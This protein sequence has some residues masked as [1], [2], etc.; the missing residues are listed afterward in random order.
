MSLRRTSTVVVGA[1]AYGLGM[2]H[3]L[4]DLGIDHLLLERGPSGDAWR[5]RR[6]QSLRLLTPNWANGLPGAPY[7]G[8]DPDGFMAAAAFADSLDS[9]R[10]R[11]A[12]PVQSGIYVTGVEQ[13]AGGFELATTRGP[14]H[15]R[16]LVAATGACGTAIRPPLADALPESV[17]QLTPADYSAPS[18]LPAGTVLI[19]GASASGVQ[20]AREIQSSGRQ[21]VLAVGRHI[22]LP[23]RYRDRDIYW[24]LDAV[25]AMDERFDRVEDL[26]RARRAPSPQLSG[27]PGAVDLTAL[28]AL[29]VELVGRLMEIRGRH[30]L[31]SGGLT[32]Q[33]AAADAKLTLLLSRFDDHAAR[34]MAG[35]DLPEP[36][37]LP[38]VLPP[39]TPR[40][41]IDLEAGEIGSVIWATGYRP[42]L[43]WLTLPVADRRGRLAHTGGVVD[44]VP[45][46]Y[47]LGLP[48]LRRRRS[49]L[50]SGI[51]PDCADLANHIATRLAASRA[52]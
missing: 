44:G 40:L 19:V 48:F 34:D 49:G 35:S 8:P 36:L 41:E 11:I 2:S 21:V 15:C 26:H 7:A 51:G 13:R 24:W 45:G 12:A 22:R 50:I 20:L 46:L 52:A 33:C 39:Q 42:A 3:A 27:G 14:I 31:F 29:G 18:D 43:D 1:G 37:R 32:H 4:S 16:S 9:Y 6:W 28:R 47:L 25:G 17:T 30:A 5:S 23:R 10:H 38:P